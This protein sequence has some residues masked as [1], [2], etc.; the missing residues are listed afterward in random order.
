MLKNEY[1]FAKIGFDTAENEPC[2]VKPCEVSPT[3]RERV[4]LMWLEAEM[5]AQQTWWRHGAALRSQSTGKP[6]RRAR[7]AAKTKHL[8]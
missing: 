3:R 5:A 4:W 2:E 7:R 1:L 6:L 8:M